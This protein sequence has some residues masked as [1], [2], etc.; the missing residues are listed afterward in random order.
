MPPSSSYLTYAGPAGAADAEA[1]PQAL[2]EAQVRQQAQV[3]VGVGVPGA[4]DL[5]WT[6]GR[7]ARGVAQ[8]RRAHVV[9]ALACVQRVAG[10]VREAYT[11]R[12]QPAARDD[13]QRRAA[14]ASGVCVAPLRGIS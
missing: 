11:R 8:I 10:V 14:R 7:A 9:R 6:G 13:Q 4:V 1:Q 2:R 3:V 5:Q 12:V